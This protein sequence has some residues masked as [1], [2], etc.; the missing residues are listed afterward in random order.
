MSC[1]SDFKVMSRFKTQFKTQFTWNKQFLIFVWFRVAHYQRRWWPYPHLSDT[2][3]CLLQPITSS[4]RLEDEEGSTMKKP[5]YQLH[6]SH[7]NSTVQVT[8]RL[9]FVALRTLA[10]VLQ[11]KSGTASHECGEWRCF[12]HKFTFSLWCCV[13]PSCWRRS[14]ALHKETDWQRFS[15]A[16]HLHTTRWEFYNC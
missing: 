13:P 12:V 3:S 5:I 4:A 14:A 7:T 1:S 8:A 9:V 16:Q 11:L 6:T 2:S 10:A 15:G